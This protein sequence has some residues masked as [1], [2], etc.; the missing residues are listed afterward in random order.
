MTSLT[1]L[2]Q[3]KSTARICG[4]VL[5]NA[6][7]FQEILSENDA[8]VSTLNKILENKNILDGFCEHWYFI[9][10]NINYF[11]IF[12]VS[13]EILINLPATPDIVD[14]L[15]GLVHTA[16]EIMEN[17]AALRHD[18]MGRI[19]HRLL[20]E[21][22]YL[23]TYYTSISAA[24][25][26]L[27]L[28]LTPDVYKVEWNK[29]ENIGQLRIADLACGT[30][31]LLMA[32]ADTV[33]DNYINE[34]TNQGNAINVKDLQNILV[35]KVLYGYDVLAS[36]IHLT[37]STLALRAP[38]I[39]FKKMNLFSLP[40]GGNNHH[41]GSIEFLSQRA[42][43]MY[44]DMFGAAKTRQI[45]GQSEH[46][47][48]EA[49]LPYLD[50]CV[51]NP[52]FTRSVGGNLLFGSIPKNERR[53]MQ[54]NL[55]KLVKRYN[56]KANIT[57]GLG[58]IFVATADNYIKANGRIAIVLPKALLSGVAWNQTR[59][60]LK[61]SYQVDYIIVSHDSQRW[62][63]SENTSLSEVLLIATKLNIDNKK[64]T[65]SVVIVNLWRNP[66]TSFEALAIANSLLEDKPPYI[67]EGQGALEV[68]I[69]QQKA[70]EALSI[71]WNTLI[72]QSNWLL[73]CSFAQSDLV[74]ATY[75]LLEG[76]LW[77]PRNGFVGK[78]PLCSLNKLGDLGFDRRDIHDGFKLS[79][80]V[81]S[82]PAFWGHDAKKVFTIGQL[83]NQYLSPR[84]KAGKGRHLRDAK[85]L[86]LLSSNI[87]IGGR[88]W[89]NT[90]SLASVRITQRVLSNVWWSFSLNKEFNDVIYE[91]ALALWLNST[92]GLLILLVHRVETRG[93]WIEFKKPTLLESPVLNLKELSNEQ[94]NILNA[95]YDDL[96][97]KALKPFPEMDN[98]PVRNEI[99]VAI[100]TTLKLP[101]LSVLRE[102]LAREPVISMKNL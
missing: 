93:A 65:G 64:P 10:E 49:P 67:V 2:K 35:E 9:I 82:F 30:G 52:P 63:F 66:T 72:K 44:L 73:P 32:A 45:A 57:A 1:S 69:G 41:L 31:T 38:E 16:H 62:N 28:A 100:S 34:S 71:R 14:G 56:V 37:A 98:D 47:V 83:P 96:A 91:K 40:L 20:S 8:R 97:N 77:L 99:D 95:A 68:N 54:I 60:L 92:L 59:T 3:N 74:R 6:M 17:R 101:D 4:L 81:T 53:Q 36:A 79:K 88:M 80:T 27:K 33:T 12:H 76:N 84:A 22:K 15:K 25:L 42:V 7:I 70:G 87:L 50:L 46:R 94:L 86:W 24:S 58:S 26:L 5:T 29:L 75:H 18:L 89:L 78:L 43:S 85:H 55:K 39:A 11:P 90:Q 48:N 51:M 19:Y 102:M 61:D 23:G 21:A 13:R